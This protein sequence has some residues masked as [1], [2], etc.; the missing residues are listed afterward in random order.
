MTAKNS[1]AKMAANRRYDEKAYDRITVRV[2]KGY[3]EQLKDIVKPDSVNGFIVKAMDK[4]LSGGN[5]LGIKDLEAYAR[6]AGVTMDQYIKSAVLEKM[7]RQDKE[8][9]EDVTSEGAEE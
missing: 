1:R 2:P 6:S 9:T 7:E 8:F 5:D 4:A 3:R